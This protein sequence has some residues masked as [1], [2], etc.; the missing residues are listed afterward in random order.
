LCVAADC[1]CSQAPNS[2]NASSMNKTAHFIYILAMVLIV[3]AA[4]AYFGCRGYQYYTTPLDQRFFMEDH[5]L[6][7]PSGFI[8]HGLGFLG[9]FLMLFGV[10]IYILKK[11]YRNFLKGI[12]LKYLLEFHIF[13]C[14]M[15]PILV[16]FHSA[17]KVGGIVSVAFW[18]MLAIVLS[19]VIGRYIYVQIPKTIEGRTLSLQEAVQLQ[20][21]LSKQ[22]LDDEQ[23]NSEL[24]EASDKFK[25]S[26]L[27]IS[28]MYI[29]QTIR[30]K[31]LT[32][33][34]GIEKR[35]AMIETLRQEAALSAR[36][37]NLAYM[38]RLFKYWHVIHQPFTLVLLLIVVFHIGVAFTFGYCWIF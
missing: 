15:G 8:G 28:R 35:K 6:L 11:R 38:N 20:K 4:T 13:L 18:S 37:K 29:I 10:V 24:R 3:V 31:M 12:R 26:R 27:W 16:I 33:G 9:T 5:D 34:V 22:L 19:G 30:R 32:M 21:V 17:F 25:Q 23:L 14:T 1:P 7:K 2:R 36:I